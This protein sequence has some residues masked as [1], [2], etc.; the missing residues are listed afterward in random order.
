MK[1]KRNISKRKNIR[2]KTRKNIKKQSGGTYPF[3]AMKLLST[4]KEII[5][6]IG[7]ISKESIQLQHIYFL[8][9]KLF[10]DGGDNQDI[11]IYTQLLRCII[12]LCGYYIHSNSKKKSTLTRTP[13]AGVFGHASKH[14]GDKKT[15]LLNNIFILF[16]ILCD[17]YQYMSNN[18]RRG[19]NQVLETTFKSLLGITTIPSQIIGNCLKDETNFRDVFDFMSCTVKNLILYMK[20]NKTSIKDCIDITQFMPENV[21]ES[22][23]EIFGNDQ[24][25]NDQKTGALKTMIFSDFD[26]ID[27]LKLFYKMDDIKFRIRCLMLF[28]KLIANDPFA[29][30]DVTILLFYGILKSDESG[31]DKLN[32]ILNQNIFK[33][34]K[35]T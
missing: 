35:I 24:I 18:H 26:S 31:K 32:E 13:F 16:Y 4:D 29:F 2:K 20:Y 34:F 11:Y 12:Q 6:D 23:D 28:K 14:T 15:I 22:M 1:T 3:Y 27:D 10:Y 19:Q 5:L 33:I 21:I 17:F 8:K 7:D 30:P 9:K 25:G